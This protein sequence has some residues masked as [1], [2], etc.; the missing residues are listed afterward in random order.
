MATE[1][2]TAHPIASVFP[3]MSKEELGELT[4]DLRANGLRFPII[5][6]EGQILDGRNRYQGCRAVG[7]KPKFEDYLGTDPVGFVVSANIHRRHLTESQRAMV[8]AKLAN[9]KH[10]QRA[11]RVDRTIGRSISQPEAAAKLQ[12]CTRNVG[13][14]ARVLRKDPEQ[15]RAVERGEKTVHK[16]LKE[17][18]PEND[19]PK[20]SIARPTFNRVNDRIS[21]A[22][23]SWNPVTGC[24]HGC[25]YCYARDLANRFYPKEGFKPTFRSERLSMPSNTPIPKSED[26]AA[27]CVFVC[28]MADLFGEWVPQKWI[29]AVLGAVRLSPQ[30]QYLFLT[31]NPKRLPSINWPP[32]CWVGAT[33][34]YCKRIDPTLDALRAV[35][36]AAVIWISA[37]PLEEDL[38]LEAADLAGID[39]VVIGGRSESS[40]CA[41]GQPDFRWTTRLSTAADTAGC[42]VYHKPNLEPPRM[43]PRIGQKPGQAARSTQD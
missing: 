17:L 5:L 18:P 23:W 25:T 16:A 19:R 9:L 15:A 3:P 41:A 8:A 22:W 21:W 11:D 1:L 28:S 2:L 29:D 43:I 12:V 13:R 27:R 37:E 7:I 36:G 4:A 32:N 31:K 40:G 6:H 14:A 38:E 39:W 24:E 33:I 26:Q 35:Q 42:D 10:G 34:D 30:W 20:K